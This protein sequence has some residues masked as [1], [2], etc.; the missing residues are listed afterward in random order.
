MERTTEY[1][2][3][4]QSLPLDEKVALTKMRIVEWYEHWN[5]NVSV[6]FSGGKDSTV[7]LDIVRSIY[8]DVP[9]V[10]VDTGLE[11]PEI[12]EFVRRFDNVT[13]VRPSM[14]FNEVLSTYGYPLISKEVSEAIWYARKNTPPVN[15]KLSGGGVFRQEQA[16]LSG[17]RLTGEGG[18]LPEHE[19]ESAARTMDQRTQRPS[20]N[21]QH[22]MRRNMPCRTWRK[23]LP[24]RERESTPTL[25]HTR[26]RRIMLRG[27]RN[28]NSQSVDEGETSAILQPTDL[29]SRSGNSRS[30]KVCPAL[31]G[32]ANPLPQSTIQESKCV[33]RGEPKESGD[34]CRGRFVTHDGASKSK[35]DDGEYP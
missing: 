31:G 35:S 32:A 33:L 2:K 26:T 6:S 5:G 13:V 19:T 3:E 15:K 28:R 34:T 17:L 25:R 29:Y 8:P 7:L 1:L 18:T 9:A 22:N 10:F 16:E 21:G 4:L 23:P 24:E 12:R 30:Q 14:P 11:Q 27:L 20:R